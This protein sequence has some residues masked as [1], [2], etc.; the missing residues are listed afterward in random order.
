MVESH[1][2]CCHFWRENSNVC[3]NR[4]L[5]PIKIRLRHFLDFLMNLIVLGVPGIVIRLWS[6]V[7]H[8]VFKNCKYHL[9][10]LQNNQKSLILIF[11]LC[12]ALLLQTFEFS[13]QKMAASKMWFY[14]SICSSFGFDLRYEPRICIENSAR[15]IASKWLHSFL[16]DPVVRFLSDFPPLWNRA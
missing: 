8:R 9:T 13:R 14:Q 15:Y 4:A 7:Q 2:C 6:Y 10:V 3:Y 1:F 5:Q 16:V 11:N 12:S